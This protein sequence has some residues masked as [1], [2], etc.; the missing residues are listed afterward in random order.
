MEMPSVNAPIRLLL[1]YDSPPSLAPAAEAFDMA[2]GAIFQELVGPWTR[3]LVE[4]RLHAQCDTREKSG[5]AF[6]TQK[7]LKSNEGWLSELGSPLVSSSVKFVVGATS[8][9]TENQLE[10]PTR[11]LQIEVLREDP[12]CVYI[13]LMSQWPQLPAMS[14]E[15]PQAIDARSIRRIDEKPSAYIDEAYDYLQG[16]VDSLAKKGSP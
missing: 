2:Y 12:R 7:F 4:V 10:G 3:V 11:E 1:S 6:I 15:A 5:L 16:R 8:P 14:L 13:E 9:V